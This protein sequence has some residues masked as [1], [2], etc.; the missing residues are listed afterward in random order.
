MPIKSRLSGKRPGSGWI[1]ALFG[2]VIVGA[3]MV[4]LALV[5]RGILHIAP[6][7]IAQPLP[8]LAPKVDQIYRGPIFVE[9]VPVRVVQETMASEAVTRTAPA[10]SGPR[11]ARATRK[12]K[13]KSAQHQVEE[14]ASKVPSPPVETCDGM[15]GMDLA[16]CMRPQVLDADLQLR[17]AYNEAVKA[18]VKRRVLVTHRRQWSKLRKRANSDPRG[19]LVGFRDI[20]QQLDAARISSHPGGSDCQFSSGGCAGANDQ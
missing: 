1:R 3:L 15:E 16:R 4:S 13:H 12:P 6:R 2:V 14:A 18:G 5:Q 19:V 10:K 7:D 11:L 9:P 8:P 20:A 17:N